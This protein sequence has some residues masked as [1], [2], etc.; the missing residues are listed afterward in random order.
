[1]VGLHRCP[2]WHQLLLVFDA[3]GLVRRGCAAAVATT[4]SS[5]YAAAARFDLPMPYWGLQVVRAC[6]VI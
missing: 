4:A 1:M 2:C 6:R 5:A 3:C